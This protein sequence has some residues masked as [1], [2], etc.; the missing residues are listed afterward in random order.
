MVARAPLADLINVD[1]EWGA[2][3]VPV[4][5]VMWL[6][7]CV[8]RGLLQSARAYREVGLSILLEALG[9]LA[10]AVVFVSAGLGV[11]GAY[12]GTLSSLAVA[13]VALAWLLRRRLGAPALDSRPHPLPALARGA[14]M[15]AF[16]LL[17]TEVRRGAPSAA[18]PN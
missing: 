18:M 7:L 10:V 11:T 3:A 9:R 8:Q 12:L 14:G 17:P 6:L 13:A 2:A 16:P 5:G 1:Q 15:G 4:T